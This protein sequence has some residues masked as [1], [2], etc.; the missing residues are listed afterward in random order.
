MIGLDTN[1]LVRYIA[2]DDMVQSGRAT[3]LIESLT[4][5]NPGFVSQIVL[6]ELVWVLKRAYHLDR[7]GILQVLRKLLQTASLVVENSSMTA[8]AVRLYASGNADFADCLALHA[9]RAAGCE[10]TWTFDSLAARDA[11]MNLL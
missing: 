2:Q 8:Q 11:G 4:E 1:V 10:Q 6:V 7:R 3:L 5:D 9:A